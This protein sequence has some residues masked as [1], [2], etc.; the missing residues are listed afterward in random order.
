MVLARSAAG[1]APRSSLLTGW[2]FLGK[3]ERRDFAGSIKIRQ[4]VLVDV[5]GDRDRAMTESVSAV[6]RRPPG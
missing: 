5:G 4:N 3:D 2:G 1:R 6:R